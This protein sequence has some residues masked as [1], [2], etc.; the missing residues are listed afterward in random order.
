MI[1]RQQTIWLIVSAI[2]AAFS[3]KFPFATGTRMIKDVLTPDSTLNAGSNFILMVLTGAAVLLAA[4]C[5]FFYKDRK[6]QMRLC[7]AGMALAILILV[8]YFVQLQ[9]F[10]KSTMALAS[11]LPFAVTAGFFMAFRGIRKDEKL[12]KT[13]DKLR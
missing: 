3:F 5:I 13:L 10:E 1:Q 4:V 9:K 12:I 6:L 2:C 8:I 7:L 11:I